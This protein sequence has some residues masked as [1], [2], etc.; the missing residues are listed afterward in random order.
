LEKKVQYES[1]FVS[2]NYFFDNQMG[3]PYFPEEGGCY[4]P[5]PVFV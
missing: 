3:K 1:N 2:V 5:L 4:F